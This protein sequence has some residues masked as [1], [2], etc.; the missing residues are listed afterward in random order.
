MCSFQEINEL[1]Q[2]QATTF[3][4]SSEDAQRILVPNIGMDFSLSSDDLK[5]KLEKLHLNV[6]RLQMH[7]ATLS[8]YWRNKRIPQGLRLQKAPT[9][10]KSNEAFV[11]R[12]SEIL[13]KCSFDLMLLIIDHVSTESSEI[14]K[15]I[16]IQ[17]SILKEKFDADFA[18]I[19]QSIKETVRHYKEKL[20]ATKLRKYKRDIDDYIRK[21]VYIWDKTEEDASQATAA[22]SQ[23]PPAS[24]TNQRNPR[25]S[26]STTSHNWR[27]AAQ[28]DSDDF[29][30]DSDSSQYSREQPFLGQRKKNKGRKRNA[31][32]GRGHAGHLPVT[33]SQK[34]R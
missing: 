1:T 13:N 4:F 27:E 28:S 33:R 29:T 30:L 24:R 9:L 31:G 8:E 22:V 17:E 15:E 14:E 34:K 19:E 16:Q 21:E 7:G 32:G 12:W 2:N 26:K 3:E 10:G 6:T 5:H 25:H 20:H 11:Q 23:Q 18:P